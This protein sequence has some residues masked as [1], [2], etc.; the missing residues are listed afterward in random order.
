MSEDTE[1]DVSGVVRGVDPTLKKLD[2]MERVFVAEWLVDFDVYRSA[3]AAGYSETMAKTKCYQWVSDSKAKP[4]VFAAAQLGLARREKRIEITADRVLKE[5]GSI[6][7]SNVQDFIGAGGDV[8]KL[9]REQA[10]SISEITLEQVT[11]VTPTNGAAPPAD[12][13]AQPTTE[14]RVLKAKYHPKHPP[15]HSLG[16]H[17]GLFKEKIDLTLK[18]GR[19]PFEV[20]MSKTDDEA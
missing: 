18:N 19:K 1:A 4:H 10:A 15:L 3:K 2:A 13:T 5:L 8:M 20:R 16:N 9:S 14:V 12:G 6:G 17:F 7:F 11:T